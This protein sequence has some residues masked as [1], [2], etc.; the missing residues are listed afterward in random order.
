MSEERSGVSVEEE[1]KKERSEQWGNKKN[2]IPRITYT[3][4]Y[5][6]VCVFICIYLF[7]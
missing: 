7:I 6:C 4:A 2:K 3:R 1:G 5:V